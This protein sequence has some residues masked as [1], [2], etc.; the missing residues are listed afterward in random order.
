MQGRFD[1]LL[2]KVGEEVEEVVVVVDVVEVVGTSGG[3]MR[4]SH[5]LAVGQCGGEAVGFEERKEK[6]HVRTCSSTV[7]FLRA[8]LDSV[9][10]ACSGVGVRSK[11]FNCRGKG[12]G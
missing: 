9:G 10:L 6:A 5:C 7:A 4:R 12:Q 8:E 3:I 11:G 1:R 2:E